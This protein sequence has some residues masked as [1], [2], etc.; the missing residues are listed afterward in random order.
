MVFA[1][2]FKIGDRTV[3]EGEETYIIAEAGVNH[4]GN[5]NLAKRLVDEAK[6]ANVDAVKFQTWKTEL[7]ISRLAPK[8]EYQK[9]ETGETENQYEM[10]KRLELSDDD[11]RE[12]EEYCRKVGVTF[13]STP[14]DEYSVV[15]LESMKVPAYKVSST[16]TTNPFLLSR[17]A[18]TKKP[19]ILSTG[20]SDI[21]QVDWAV[22]FLKGKG[23]KDLIL[24]QCTTSYPSEYSALNIRSMSYLR[25]RYSVPVGFSDHSA[26]IVASIVAV[27]LGACVIEKHFTLDKDLPGPDHK[28]SLDTTELRELVK[29]IRLAEASLGSCDKII[30]STEMEISKVARRSIFVSQEILKGTI[31]EEGML[32]AKRPGTGIPPMRFNEI[33]G[34]RAK[35]KIEADEMLDWEML[36]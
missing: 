18:S 20:M 11:F 16:D 30:M 4:N 21:E 10:V 26:G 29:A 13:L 6:A 3:G 2:R 35:R 19:I 15:L 28:A 24:L 8:A 14:F 33:I 17:I 31:I 25:E 34:R 36:E 5:L 9:T 22:S 32:R 12:L 7:G 27:G 23:V 1:K